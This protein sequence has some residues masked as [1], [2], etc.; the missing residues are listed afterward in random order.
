MRKLLSILAL[1]CLLTLAAG[2]SRKAVGSAAPPPETRSA[3]EE[4]KTL[5]PEG[6]GDLSPEETEQMPPEDG[7]GPASQ[8]LTVSD[9]V[10]GYCGNTVTSVTLD[11]KTYSF[12]GSDSVSLTDIVINLDYQ[13][14]VCRC[15]VEFTVDTEFGEGYGVNLT[16]SFARCEAG[17]A[18]LT[19][20]QAETIRAVLERNCTEEAETAAVC[21]YDQ[22]T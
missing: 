18:P 22:I 11:G 15:P 17:Q 1:V 21:G 14:E 12:W 2:C 9:P 4:T 5:S 7:H 8:P 10:E 16:E 6:T 3:P 19:E 13:A 20:E